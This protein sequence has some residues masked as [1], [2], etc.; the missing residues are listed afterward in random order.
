MNR[1][2]LLQV[3][4]VH[5]PER[6]EEIAEPR[7]EPLDGVVMNLADAVTVIVTRPLAFAR[8]MAY[9]DVDALGLG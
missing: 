9:G 8:C 1:N 6:A 7:P 5:A 4:L 2:V 3:H